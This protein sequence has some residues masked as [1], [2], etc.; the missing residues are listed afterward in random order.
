LSVMAIGQ[1][2]E[3]KV[4]YANIMN[5]DDRA[6]GRGGT[7][8]VAGS[9]NL[10]AMVIK[11]SQK[12]N[13]PDAAQPDKYNEAVK[14]GLTAIMEGALTAPRKGGLSVY[15]TNVLMNIVN[16]VGALPSKNSTESYFPTADEIS[17]ETV[18]QELL[19]SDP[20]CHA[21]PVACKIE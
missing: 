3:N 14:A 2:G 19:V 7:G 21:C 5:E 6:C 12:G 15:G 8:A 1:A 11:A 4:L 13:M 16:E 9:K 18:R 17:G 20:T 10:K